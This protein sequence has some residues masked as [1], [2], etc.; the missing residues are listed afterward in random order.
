MAETLDALVA[1]LDQQRGRVGQARIVVWAH[2][3]HVGDARA[4]EV[5]ADGQHTLGQLV[6]ERYEDQCR[7]IGFST[8]G[9]TVTAAN[10]WGG[11]SQR[12]AVRPGL[13]GSLEEL[14]HETEQSSF[15]VRMDQS[16]SDEAAE[17][18][19]AVRLHRAIGVIYRPETERHSHYFHVRPA[20]QYDAIIHLDLTTALEPLEPTSTWIQ[21]QTPETYPSGL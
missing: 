2:N 5:G 3:S 11:P 16:H 15:L 17:T 12:K 14:F 7:L 21:G 10:E 4:T 18:L 1:H 19:Q 6:R 20:D 9:G 8:Y 13:P